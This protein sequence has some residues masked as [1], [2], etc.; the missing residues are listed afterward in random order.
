[1]E[2]PKKQK[3]LALL[4]AR[5]D[6]R[7]LPGK[8]LK[9]V[10]G[11][12]MLWY[13]IERLRS[14]SLLDGIVLITT[15]RELDDHLAEFAVHE[16][17]GLFRGELEDVLGRFY[18]AASEHQAD[19]IV[20]VNGDSPWLDPEF[21]N[22]GI[23]QMKEHSFDFLTGKA[24]FTGLPVG[25]APEFMT[26]PTLERLNRL[27]IEPEDREH[28]T[29]YIF[30]FPESFHWAPLKVIDPEKEASDLDLCVDTVSDFEDFS[31]VVSRLGT[32]HPAQWS[33]ASI[34]AAYERIENER[35]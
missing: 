1:L 18:Q 23:Q 9:D 11:K 28:V 22:Q 12:P 3:T 32:C 21:V 26:F 24:R 2:L 30:N 10:C 5:L 15:D 17:L 7:R 25:A 14:V 31:R 33:M 6:S 27:A 35:I 20:R 34:I 8:G 4:P 13:L 16:K 29:T 19:L